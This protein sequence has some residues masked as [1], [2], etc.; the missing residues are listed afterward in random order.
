MQPELACISSTFVTGCTFRLP[1]DAR[2][3]DSCWL[4]SAEWLRSVRTRLRPPARVR[5][6]MGANDR[7]NLHAQQNRLPAL[8]RESLVTNFL[9][10]RYGSSPG[11]AS[12][13]YIARINYRG[14]DFTLAYIKE[15]ATFIS[16]IFR[17]DFLVSLF[18]FSQ[19]FDQLSR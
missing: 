10:S 4:E 18:A 13:S 16:N 1:I 15:I 12:F 7:R 3:P 9:P 5:T 8:R 2:R 11:L 19:S 17:N 6:A 14:S